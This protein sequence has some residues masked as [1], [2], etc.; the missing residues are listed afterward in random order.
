MVDLGTVALAGKSRVL[1]GG[2]HLAVARALR[3]A[4]LRPADW[5]SG[6][7]AVFLRSRYCYVPGT[8]QM[9][10]IYVPQ[11]M[12]AGGPPPAHIG[13]HRRGRS[14]LGSQ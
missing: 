4:D 13:G 2:R 5:R 7:S 12:S 14:A 9:D 11:N 8:A 6:K 10:L 1:S 3:P